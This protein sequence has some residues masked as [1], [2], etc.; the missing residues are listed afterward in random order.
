MTEKI[1]N[2]ILDHEA[3]CENEE[4]EA[5]KRALA[6]QKVVGLFSRKINEKLTNLKRSNSNL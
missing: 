6:P 3:Y 2:S 4:A 5:P 1:M